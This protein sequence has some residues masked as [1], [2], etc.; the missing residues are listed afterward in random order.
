MRQIDEGKT[1]VKLANPKSLEYQVLINCLYQ[2]V[3]TSLLPGVLKTLHSNRK[4]PLPLKV[5]EVSDVVLK[6]DKAE[7]RANNHRR[8]CAVYSN[9]TSGFEVVFCC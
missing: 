6:D 8:V 5:F 9:K 2:V 3:R 4:N 7:R 1:A